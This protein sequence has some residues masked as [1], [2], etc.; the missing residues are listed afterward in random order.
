MSTSES[1]RMAEEHRR[2]T[3]RRF[4]HAPFPLYGLTAAWS[5][6]RFLGGWSGGLRRGLHRGSTDCLSLVHGSIVD[7]AGPALVA[8]TARLDFAP[9]GGPLR[10]VAEGLWGGNGSWNGEDESRL[11]PSQARVTINVNGKPTALDVVST[12]DRWVGRTELDGYRVTVE[13]HD[14]PLTDLD[15]VAIIDL[16]PYLEGTRRFYS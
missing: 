9:G 10:V 12:D 15:L 6:E 3:E 13:G 4:L 14:F 5:G 7:G 16:G 11:Q 8:E 1:L 2:E